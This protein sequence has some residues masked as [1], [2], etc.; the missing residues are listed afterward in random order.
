MREREQVATLPYRSTRR[1]QRPFSRA[2]REDLAAVWKAT[3]TVSST[4]FAF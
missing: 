2:V 4:R 3:K 1:K